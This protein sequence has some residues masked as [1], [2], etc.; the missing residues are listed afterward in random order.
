MWHSIKPDYVISGFR[1]AGIVP[2]CPQAV[3]TSAVRPSEVFHDT[4]PQEQG[5]VEPQ[6]RGEM[7]PQEQRD[8]EFQEQEEREPLGKGKD[9]NRESNCCQLI[10]DVSAIWKP[11]QAVIT[12]SVTNLM[13]STT[14]HLHHT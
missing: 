9:R 4:Q 1:K 14:S 11:L 13:T 2:F 6:Q 12:T 5:E 7:E 3:S 8:M 10:E